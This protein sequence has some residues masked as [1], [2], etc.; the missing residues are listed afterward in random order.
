[1]Q[2]RVDALLSLRGVACLMVVF[3]HCSPPREFLLC[4]GYD[5]SWILFAPG[6][7]AVWIFFT[8]SGYLMGKGFY[9]ERYKT[10]KQGIFN[11]WQNRALRILPLY[12]FVI[13]VLSVF[14]YPDALR[15]K[16]WEQYARLFTFTYRLLNSDLIDIDAPLWSLSTEVQFY[17]MVPFI[18]VFTHPFLKK[19]SDI[20]LFAVAIISAVFGLKLWVSYQHEIRT[21]L[22][23]AVKYWYTPLA[24]NVDIFIC[25]FL[26]NPLLKSIRY[27]VPLR[28]Q[29]L[30]KIAS[31]V[32]L[33]IFYCTSAYYF[34]H[35][36]LGVSVNFTKTTVFLFQPLTALLTSFFVFAFELQLDKHGKNQ[37]L[38]PTS[39]KNNPIRALEVI[40][41]LSFGIYVWHLPIILRLSPLYTSA[42]LWKMYCFRLV[43]ALTFS[44][45]LAIT[46]YYLI[47]VPFAKYKAY[48]TNLTN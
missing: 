29:K 4:Q 19:L 10:D 23:L 8:L 30:M 13:V 45:A 20:L 25:G 41:N 7:V 6:G 26:I 31:V 36:N 9:T 37:K 28:Q 34:Y 43:I 12:I 1:M 18:Y 32:L 46:T 39:I 5:F 27:K 33:V 15:P 21:N 38:L 44:T 3:I 47:E 48:K 11:F 14:A 40:G 24:T 35:T 17:L 42:A 16:N 22:I 2:N